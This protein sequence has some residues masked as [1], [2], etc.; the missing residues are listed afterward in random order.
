M[1]TLLFEASH[2]GGTVIRPLFFEFPKDARAFNNVEHNFMLGPGLKIS[3][4]M[5]PEITDYKAYFPRGK[6]CHVFSGECFTSK[7]EDRDLNGGLDWP[8]NIHLREG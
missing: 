3:P 2:F 7:G 6:W 8:I 4:V 5:E 1:Y